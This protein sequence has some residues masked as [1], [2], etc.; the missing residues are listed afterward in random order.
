MPGI[1]GFSTQRGTLKHKFTDHRIVIG[2]ENEDSMKT[3]RVVIADN[4]PVV[5]TGHAALLNQRVD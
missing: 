4:H 2:A 1:V 5:R 3:V